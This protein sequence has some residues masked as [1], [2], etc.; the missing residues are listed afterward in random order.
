MHCTV[1]VYTAR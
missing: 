1:L